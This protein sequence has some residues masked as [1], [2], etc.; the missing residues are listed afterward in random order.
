MLRGYD[1]RKEQGQTEA[2]AGTSGNLEDILGRSLQNLKG[3]ARE[4]PRTL[5][6]LSL[7]S[8]SSVFMKTMARWTLR[9]YP[10]KNSQ[11]RISLLTVVV[12]VCPF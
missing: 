10:I 11:S 6:L 3:G 12:S 7:T 9:S 4:A 8:L 2:K 1:R 5:R